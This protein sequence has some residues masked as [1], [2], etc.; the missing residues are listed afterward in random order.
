MILRGII[1]LVALAT[2]AS[3]N[4]LKIVTHTSTGGFTIHARV[5]AQHLQKYTPGQNVSIKIVP[6][7]AGIATA[8][9]LYNV[10]P[11]DG[12]E[13]GTI[14][15]KVLTQ[16]L[17]KNDE[18]KYDLAKFG[19][20]GSSVDGRKEPF[21]LWA[22]TG[23]DQLIAGSEGGF[24]INHIKLVN[25]ILRWDMREVVGYAES[26]QVRMAFEKGEI[27]LVAYNLTGIRTT[28]P[29]WLKDSSV[30]PMVQYG[31]GLARHPDLSF[32]PTV[33]ELSS[34]DDDKNL[35]TAFERLL[36]LGRAFAAPPGLSDDKLLQLRN[37][38]DHVIND[39]EYRSNA[40]KIGV[41]VSPVSWKEAEE[42]V[43]SM[44][45]IKPETISKMT[46]F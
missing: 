41:I 11:K 6:G 16:G 42:I 7:A 24:A 36:I 23:P 31:A 29:A 25:S 35:I 18:V 38:F 34:S 3:A 37:L 13:I 19:W 44:K 8:N 15:T 46:S 21:V 20:L 2:A 39:P 45:A 9:Y 12:S 33:M 22:K 26:G 4:D 32:V 10:A 17:I 14:N 43:M 27:N 30:L 1:A 40:A 28:A 5:F